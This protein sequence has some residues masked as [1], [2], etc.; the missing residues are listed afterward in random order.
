MTIKEDTSFKAKILFARLPGYKNRCQRF[1]ANEENRVSSKMSTYRIC[2]IAESQ[3]N[4]CNRYDS[5]NFYLEYRIVERFT[6]KEK[7]EKIEKK[8]KG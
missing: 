8:Y 5:T 4:R 6:K 7:Q 1:A 3:W 2:F